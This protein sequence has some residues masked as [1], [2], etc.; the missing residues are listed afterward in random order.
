MHTLGQILSGVGVIG[1][2][3]CFIMVLIAMFQRGQT[4]L[5]IVCIVT[6]I[7]CCGIG[8]LVAFIYGWTKH[9]QW[10]LTN[11]MWAWTACWVLGFVGSFLAPVDISQIQQQFPGH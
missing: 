4:G 10:G 3:I 2:L 9:R 8:A 7:F 6:A 11:I 1:S 5:G